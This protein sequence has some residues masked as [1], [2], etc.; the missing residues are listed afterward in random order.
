MEPMEENF[1]EDWRIL[2]RKNIDRI[3]TTMNVGEALTR[4]SSAV[5]MFLMVEDDNDRSF[6][7]AVEQQRR[8][9]AHTKL[10]FRVSLNGFKDKDN[11]ALFDSIN[12]LPFLEELEEAVENTFNEVRRVLA[13]FNRDRAAIVEAEQAALL[14]RKETLMKLERNLVEMGLFDVNQLPLPFSADPVS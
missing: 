5:W 8:K 4:L 1:E 10:N 7:F 6:F 9:D 12:K 3:S 2:R 14:D 13:K 11:I